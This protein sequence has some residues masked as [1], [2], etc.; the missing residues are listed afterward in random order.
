V[1]EEFADVMIFI[2]GMCEK[3]GFDLEKELVAKIEKNKRRKYRKEKSPDGK[4]IFIRI[5]S[6]QDP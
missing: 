1:A 6:P 3:Y 2:L 4:D 5:K